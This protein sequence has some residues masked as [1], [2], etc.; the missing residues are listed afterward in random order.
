[1]KVQKITYGQNQTNKSSKGVQFE[2]YVRV[3]NPHPNAVKLD[4]LVQRLHYFI[5]TYTPLSNDMMVIIKRYVIHANSKGN[6]EHATKFA[7]FS[8]YSKK[9]EPV[10]EMLKPYN[11]YKANIERYNYYVGKDYETE[12]EKNSPII[13]QTNPVMDRMAKLASIYDDTEKNIAE[14]IG[15]IKL[16]DIDPAVAKEES[17]VLLVGKELKAHNKNLFLKNLQKGKT[18]ILSVLNAYNKGQISDGLWQKMHFTNWQKLLPVSYN[19]FDTDLGEMAIDTMK[20]KSR[21]IKK[22]MKKAQ[23][24]KFLPQETVENAYG[25]YLNKVKT[26]ITNNEEAMQQK[27]GAGPNSEFIFTVEDQKELKKVL[28]EQE[29]I[30]RPFSD[31]ALSEQSAKRRQAERSFQ[32]MFGIDSY[33]ASRGPEHFGMEDMGFGL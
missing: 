31:R 24:D 11:K 30:L 21:V 28:D 4:R 18:N 7:T 27:I 5:R 15:K 23:A 20:N 2:K 3:A 22:L 9:F 29:K 33:T 6:I 16:E 1:M 12:V 10:K 8:T 26:I 14:E 32:Q 17:N 13:H 19:Q 25:V